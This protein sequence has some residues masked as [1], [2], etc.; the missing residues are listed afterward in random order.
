MCDT[1]SFATAIWHERYLGFARPDLVVPPTQHLWLLTDH[2]GVPFEDDGLRDG[3][4]LRPWMTER[5][6]AELTCTGRRFVTLT[7]TH[8]HRLA[9]AVAAVDALLADGWAIADPL[10]ER[11]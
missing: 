1:D 6:R 8:E 2:V 11:R 4:H 5:F 10:P 7:G 3:E 9:T